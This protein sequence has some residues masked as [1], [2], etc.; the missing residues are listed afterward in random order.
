M[1][2]VFPF[3]VAVSCQ[4]GTAVVRADLLVFK[5]QYGTVYDPLIVGAV[6]PVHIQFRAL[7][8]NPPLPGGQDILDI[9][10]G[11]FHVA[12]DFAVLEILHAVAVVEV[13]GKRGTVDDR[14]LRDITGEPLKFGVGYPYVGTVYAG[15]IPGV[16]RRAG[17]VHPLTLFRGPLV[18]GFVAVIVFPVILF[19][20][21]VAAPDGKAQDGIARVIQ[22]AVQILGISPLAALYAVEDHFLGIQPQAG[23]MIGGALH[24]GGVV[25]VVQENGI[26]HTA[27]RFIPDPVAVGGIEIILIGNPAA[28]QN[29]IVPLDI[30]SLVAHPF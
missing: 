11:P 25:P 4:G 13:G 7:A 2:Q 27:V 28:V 6:I 14:F 3:Q 22:Q 29:G 9:D 10:V 16:L 26:G 12:A 24:I 5:G 20:V 17:K 21:E 1:D 18:L 19:P 30:A 15:I 8:L 23:G